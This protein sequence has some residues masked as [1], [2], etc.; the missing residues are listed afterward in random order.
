MRV[1]TSVV[2]GIIAIPV[3]VVV[4]WFL[5]SR[6]VIWRY[7]QPF[8]CVARGDPEE[9]VIE[10]LGKPHRI[11]TEHQTQ[12]AW[13]SDEREERFDGDCVVQFRYIPW[14][15]SGD[16]YVIGFDSSKHAVSKYEITSP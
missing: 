12:L 13:R 5:Y 1:V 8:E 16:E 15:P 3:A 4:A 11:A 6:Y 9:H 14:P 7:D 2:A 10:L